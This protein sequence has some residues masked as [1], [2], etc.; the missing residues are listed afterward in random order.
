MTSSPTFV[1]A[2]QSIG[3]AMKLSGG[4][5]GVHVEAYK[6]LS[7]K[8]YTVDPTQFVSPV[9]SPTAT[10]DW[11]C[12]EVTTVVNGMVVDTQTVVK[13]SPVKELI[14]EPLVTINIPDEEFP[15]PY[16]MI[17]DHGVEVSPGEN[18]EFFQSSTFLMVGVIP[19]TFCK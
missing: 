1:Y 3:T 19:V 17:L 12:N 7:N 13:S 5:S 16:D 4:Q 14:G 11:E 2:G 15:Q 10:V 6:T 8:T 18:V 9:L